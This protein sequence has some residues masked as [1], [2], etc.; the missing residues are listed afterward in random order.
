M[1][2]KT[3]FL[4]VLLT[5][6]GSTPVTA[7]AAE[8]GKENS[9]V[10]VAVVQ[11]HLDGYSP[12]EVTL[13]QADLKHIRALSFLTA[14]K[15]AGSK[16]QYVG[17]AGSPGAGKSTTLEIYMQDT[18]KGAPGCVY[19]DPDQRALKF[20]SHT[21]GQEFTSFAWSTK[22][23]PQ[24]LGQRAYTKWR[25]GSNYIANTLLNEAFE[26]GYDIAH[27][28]TATA[29]QVDELY[30]K[31]RSAGYEITLLLCGAA[32]ES[33]V[34]SLEHRAKVQSFCQVD[35]GDIVKK[36]EMF[37]ERFPVY[38]RYA[39]TI[40]VYWFDGVHTGS[41]LAATLHKGQEPVIHNAEAFKHFTAQYDKG[42][43]GKN[44]PSLEELMR[45]F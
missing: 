8:P 17:T 11:K 26:G 34:N 36:G 24:D 41:T 1:Q 12:E 16:K 10:P 23:T 43:Q 7:A 9:L 2:L 25:G 14:K 21:Y 22:L 5:A 30:Q 18:L 37:P 28:T 44:L 19:V 15:V 33:R 4:A 29:K 31:L 40:L 13:I 38:F 42:R 32:D 35:P 3:L 39:D 20:M 6:L 45:K 27:G